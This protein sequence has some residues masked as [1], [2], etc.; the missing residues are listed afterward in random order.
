MN[1]ILDGRHISGISGADNNVGAD[2]VD[3]SN[4]RDN[5]DTGGI[6]NNFDN[7]NAYAK[8][9]FSTY[10]IAGAN[11]DA[12][13]GDTTGTRDVGST[14]VINNNTDG[15]NAY[16][17][18]SFSTYNVAGTNADTS[19]GAGNRSGTGKKVSNN[20]NSTDEGQ[21]KK[22][23]GANKGDVSG[24][25]IESGKKAGIG[26]VISTDNSADSG[27][28]VTDWHI[29]L[30]GLAFAALAPADCA[31]NSNLAISEG[32]PSNAASSTFNEF[33]ATF[34]V[35]ANTTLKRESKMCESNPFLFVINY[36]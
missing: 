4:T 2:A 31:N 35:F 20:I 3:T 15:K 12:D 30:A 36:Q 27:G 1:W 6:D 24:A 22:M 5:G 11:T 26:V 34:A 32:T 33:L 9:G 21:S 28:K 13:V 25:N 10:N 29:S 18:A 14:N 16:A 8:A 17:K 23:G 19:A 7:K